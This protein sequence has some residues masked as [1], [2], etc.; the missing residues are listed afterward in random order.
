MHVTVVRVLH[1]A[2]PELGNKFEHSVDEFGSDL[3]VNPADPLSP[4][5]PTS[6]ST[7]GVPTTV[8]AP[9][10]ERTGA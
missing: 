1:K 4:K 10:S 9:I 8:A 2:S 7:E 6:P 3:P 5:E